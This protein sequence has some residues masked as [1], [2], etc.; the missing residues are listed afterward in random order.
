[1]RQDLRE[2]L[3]RNPLPTDKHFGPAGLVQYENL[4]E[5]EALAMRHD[6]TARIAVIGTHG[7]RNLTL[8]VVEIGLPRLGLRIVARENFDNLAVTVES[9]RP[10]ARF[11]DSAV[12]CGAL[13]APLFDG[14]A[15]AK[16][17]IHGPRVR[18]PRRFS[19]HDFGTGGFRAVLV[20]V[21][22]GL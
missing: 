8:P 2:W 21:L 11:D 9:E 12:H 6:P 15:A 19:F 18:N 7:S 1:M 20:R 3:A 4:C 16:A 10:L 22:A 5:T 13:V 14:F 17:P